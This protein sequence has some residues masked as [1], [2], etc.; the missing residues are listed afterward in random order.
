VLETHPRRTCKKYWRVTKILYF[1]TQTRY[2]FAVCNL[3]MEGIFIAVRLGYWG[4][5]VAM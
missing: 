3:C 5:L 2:F 4:A 1:S